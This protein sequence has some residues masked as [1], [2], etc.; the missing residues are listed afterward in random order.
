MAYETYYRIHF[1]QDLWERVVVLLQKKDGVPGTPIQDYA[2]VS[3]SLSKNTQGEGKFAAITGSELI[4]TF[5]MRVADVDYWSDFSTAEFD[6]W[7]CV[8]TIDTLPLF[9]GFVLPDEGEV[10][11]QDRPYDATIRAVD[12]L[13]LLKQQ[14]LTDMNGVAFESEFTIME[15]IAGAL[16]KTLLDLEIRVYD[17]VY[18][19]TMSTRATDMKWDFFSQSKL[20][21][22]TFQKDAV[23]FVSC[24]EAL[25]IIFG[26]TYKLFY[27][28]GQWFIMRMGLYQFNPSQTY[29]TVYS[30]DLSSAVGFEE[31]GTYSTVGKN[32]LIYPR[33]EDQIKTVKFANKSARTNYIYTPWPELPKNN[34]FERGALIPLYSGPGYT[35]FTIDDWNYGAYRNQ[36]TINLNLPALPATTAQAF[37]KSTYNVYGVETER[38]LQ[39]EGVPNPGGSPP[40]FGIL[41]SDGIP[42]L[43]GDRITINFQQR[44]SYSGT[45]VATLAMIFIK[46][47]P[48]AVIKYFID[49]RLGS[50]T[51]PLHWMTDTGN[52]YVQKIYQTGENTN[53]WT[54]IDVEPPEIPVDGILYIGFVAPAYTGNTIY[55]KDF[56]VEY[57]PYVAGGYIEVKGEYFKRL[58]NANYADVSETEIFLSNNRHK[59][60]KG[61]LLNLD[62]TAMNPDLSRY[63][64]SESRSWI[65]LTNLAEFNH[66]YRRYWGI[67]GSFN[68]TKYSPF[69][70][71]T[72]IQPLSLHKTYK[73]V[74]IATE[75]RYFMLLTPLEMDLIVGKFKATFAEVNMVPLGTLSTVET[76]EELLNR[77]VSEINSTTE[78]QWD[79][80]S[81]APF[82]TP[83]FPPIAAVYTFQPRSI[84]LAIGKDYN[85]TASVNING[86]GNSPS[87]TE[88]Y[89]QIVSPTGRLIIWQ[90]GT[91]IAEDNIFSFIAYGHTVSITVI[92]SSTLGGTD[93]NQLGDS[94]TS[95]YIF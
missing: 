64:V 68:A 43:K 40:A 29:Y 13:A 9:H 34:K 44:T 93:G 54:L 81:G 86:A 92:A 19:S 76:M 60:F 4:M 23:V 88:T 49:G 70:D 84:S 48:T 36:P 82:G 31:V 80:A 22:R 20:D 35:S 33:D 1:D 85:M 18:E 45:G 41:M 37:R 58:Q 79:S 57:H 25:E 52:Q 65:D 21:Y 91:D 71:P 63:G 2:A 53:Q 30:S 12:G 77:I 74:D 7:K 69:N 27:Q 28:A 83:Y 17:N 61:C 50:E 94:S 10:P 62:G 51:N 89:N 66:Y 8:A 73:F 78:T 46:P 3:V 26:R 24:Y 72:N 11:F 59:V 55:I 42:V 39:L 47:N 32:E 14:P 95:N 6:T 5:D 75:D 90:L 87:I 67:E 15:Y 16:K 38:Q 56:R